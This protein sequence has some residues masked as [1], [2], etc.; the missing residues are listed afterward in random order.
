M[1]H[2]NEHGIDY[3]QYDCP[4][5][6]AQR[7]HDELLDELRSQGEA[8]QEKRFNP[9]DYVC[10]HCLYRTLLH[11]AT[12]CPICHGSVD[13]RHWVELIEAG[14]RAEKRRLA[15]LERTR[16]A[17]EREK[18]GADFKDTLRALAGV[19]G[20]AIF[21][22]LPLLSGLSANISEHVA[23]F[24]FPASPIFILSIPALNWVFWLIMLGG[25]WST[26]TGSWLLWSGM[27]WAFC[28]G[29]AL[30]LGVK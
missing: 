7:R 4:K 10:P 28:G 26:P 18:A 17:R 19:T 23:Q 12:R 27:F 22:F 2:C 29:F 16:P 9:G 21:V 6:V 25:L 24:N 13:A 30:R 8:S 15:E 11:R 14:A 5:C 20:V 1:Q 3:S